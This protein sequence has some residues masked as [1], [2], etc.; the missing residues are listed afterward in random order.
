MAT[1]TSSARVRQLISDAARAID[2]GAWAKAEAACKEALQYEP[3]NADGWY[4]LAGIAHRL[5]RLDEAE[6]LARKAISIDSFHPGCWH[7]LGLIQSSRRRT[8]DAVES[9][10]RTVQLAPRS[11]PAHNSLGVALREFGQDEPAEAAFRQ[12][13]VADPRNAQAHHNLAVLLA[14]RGD[15]AQ[16]VHH[17]EQATAANPSLARSH[18][19]LGRIYVDLGRGPEAEERFRKA[20]ALDPNL[21]EANNNLGLLVQAQGQVDEALRLFDTALRS[22]PDF[23]EA[24]NNLALTRYQ[25]GDRAQAGPGFH[26]ALEI[27]PGFGP[28]WWNLANFE[29]DGGNLAEARRLAEEGLRRFPIAPMAHHSLGMLDL[30]EGRFETAWVGYAWRQVVAE[31]ENHYRPKVP[32]GHCPAR[33]DAPVEYAAVLGEQGLGDQVFFARWAPRLREVA[34]RTTFYGEPRL[35]AMLG[36]SGAFDEVRE[37]ADWKPGAAPLEVRLGD[38]PCLLGPGEPIPDPLPLTADPQRLEAMRKRLAALGP[39]PYVGITWRAGTQTIKRYDKL[40]KEVPLGPFLEAV[41]RGGGT[42]VSLQR[43]AQEAEL[44]LARNKASVADFGDT[45]DD[46]EDALALLALLDDYVGVSNTNMH[47][48]AGLGL[49]TRVLVPVPPEWRY[50]TSGDRSPFFPHARLYR[51]SFDHGWAAALERLAADLARGA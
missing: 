44:A 32:N 3:R 12:A 37:K 15:N 17:Y 48:R 40:S 11:S 46:L 28:A 7:T 1:I 42:L 29:K 43:A 33:P 18:C 27:D 8:A 35:A 34:R 23:A 36:R 39:A 50:G 45:N 38:L 24:H 6:G 25:M 5:G 51:E 41:S 49:S 16:A 4:I 31:Y 13:L 9:F 47:L 14:G 26:R 21:P 22:R 10:R 2:A 30:L 19:N 20:L